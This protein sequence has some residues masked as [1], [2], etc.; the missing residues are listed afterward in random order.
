M[1]PYTALAFLVGVQSVT[2]TSDTIPAVLFGVPGTT[3][4]AATVLDGHPM[5]RRGEAGRAFGAAFTASVAGGLFGA[6]VLALSVPLLRPFILAIGTPELLAICL[7][8]L[9]F[10]ISLSAGAIAKGLIAAAL[11]LLLSTIGD[12]PQTGELRWTFGQFYLW[13]GLSLVPLALGLFA[14]PEL[15]ELAAAR[16][17]IAGNAKPER[18]QQLQGMR[19]VARNWWLVLRCSS[20][21]TLLGAIPGIG[22][23]VI[24]W[25]AYGFASRVLKGASETFGKGDVRGVIASESS[26]NAKEGGALVPTLAFG[27]PGSASMALLLGAFLIHGVAPGPEMLGAKLDVTFTMIW[28]VA[29]ANILGAGACF[30]FANQFALIAQLRAGVLVPLVF[31]VMVIGAYQGASAY[32]D[33]LVLAAAG[34]LGWLMK[35]QGWPRPPLILAFVLG[36]L[37]ENYLFISTLR[38]GAGWM[39]LPV[40]LAVWAIAFLVIGIPVINHLRARRSN[41]DK[42]PE[43]TAE[44]PPAK[45]PAARAVD[46]AMWAGA[47]AL[48]VYVIWSSA[49][50]DLPARLMPQALA[51]VALAG[52]A[53]YWLTTLM[54]QRREGAPEAAKGP[55][56]ARIA[57]QGLWL[58]GLVLGIA[59]IGMLPAIACFVLAYTIVEARLTPGRALLLTLPFVAA[60]FLLFH[61]T[62]HIPWPQSYLGDLVPALRGFMG[63]RI[64]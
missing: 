21:G 43:N 10:V 55:P 28:S 49:G 3:G 32:A 57:T 58:A 50:W 44:L 22:A 8:G 45:T 31:G 51:G 47:A 25:I 24:D 53:A 15:I 52:I 26:N 5:A 7:L 12:E 2:T 1:D 23:N 64:L 9:T 36:G 63:L 41:P 34:A 54:V 14:I 62:L 61:Q 59:L 13:D 42:A 30:L 48:F 33:L 6:L 11:G 16:T 40:P 19:D 60:L 18:W 56:L 4:S 20:I 35:R 29:L 46:V 39:V 38:Y 17:S 37:I 27:V